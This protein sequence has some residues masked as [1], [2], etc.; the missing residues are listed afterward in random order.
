MQSV[1]FKQVDAFTRTPLLGNP[2]GVVVDGNPYTD[3]QMQAIAREVNLSETA[4]IVSSTNN[5]ADIRIRWFSPLTEVPLCGHA[6]VAAFHAL[7][8]ERK[9]GMEQDGE[10]HFNLETM[11]GILPVDVV[12]RQ[13]V[14]TVKFGLTM[15]KLQQA[16]QQKVDLIRLLNITQ[17]EFDNDIP[18]MRDNYIFVPVRRLHTLF[19]IKPNFVTTAFFLESRN[20]H[21]LCVYTTET[22]E[23]ESKVHSRFFAPNDG[24]NEDPVTGSAHGPLAVILYENNV[25]LENDGKCVFQGEQGDAIGRRGRVMV[26][27]D[28]EQ[29]KPVALKISGKA[30]TVLEGDLLI[31][32]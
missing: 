14:N 18:T 11:S 31:G 28:L 22:V 8:E 3:Q 12:K 23:R 26:E 1:H 5:H 16:M 24:I 15:P 13:G 30:V 7:A 9:Y 20:L 25:I 17:G 4:F 2:A 19:N 29:H 6:T 27:L 21:G 32:E 10:Y